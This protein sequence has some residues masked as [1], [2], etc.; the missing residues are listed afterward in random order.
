[1][2]TFLTK[3][4]ALYTKEETSPGTWADPLD[5]TNSYNNPV[6]SDVRIRELD[7]SIDTEKDD[8][9]SYYLNGTFVGDESIIGKV[10]GNISYSIKFAPGEFLGTGPT[11]SHKLNYDEF[12]AS[13]ALFE[14]VVYDSSISMASYKYPAKY[15]FYPTTDA[16]GNT[17]SQTVVDKSDDGFGIEYDMKGSVNNLTIT[18]DGV[19]KPL[20]MKFEGNGGVEQ[21][22]EICP[23]DMDKIKF[24]A[25]NV[26]DTVAS[27]FLRTEILVEELDASGYVVSDTIT[28]TITSASDNSGVTTIVITLSD[29]GDWEAEYTTTYQQDDSNASL[30]LKY[31][32]SVVYSGTADATYNSTD[33]EYSFTS[34]GTSN[35][36]KVVGTYKDGSAPTGTLEITKSHSM[37]VCV[38]KF[39]L[40]TGNQLA[41]VDCQEDNSGLRYM[42]ITDMQPRVTFNP[43][44]AKLSDFDFFKA[45]TKGKKYRLTLTVTDKDR[46]DNDFNPLKIVVPVAQLLDS[47]VTDDNGF[48]R[49]EFTW[50]PLGNKWNYF[51]TIIYKDNSGTDQTY[52]SPYLYNTTTSAYEALEAMYYI[53]IEEENVN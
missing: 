28:P 33:D 41:D 3:A 6:D 15:L 48:L 9:N 31:C 20:T 49:N 19:G 42:T 1:M 39:E 51:P 44:L 22:I 8:E 5:E 35:I 38:N 16:V 52:Q 36:T 53:I 14:E 47:P 43:L 32:G 17:L 34:T 4:R 7:F 11:Y 50:R 26:M 37:T 25:K 40:Q 10:K 29:G 13:A 23:D 46:S 2:S 30:V 12:L 45:L 24:D 27:K 18:A 21:V